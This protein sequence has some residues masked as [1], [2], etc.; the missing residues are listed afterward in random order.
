MLVN[1]R[2]SNE[3]APTPAGTLIYAYIKRELKT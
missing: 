1:S 2:V 3:G